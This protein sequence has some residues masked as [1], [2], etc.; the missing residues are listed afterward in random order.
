MIIERYAIMFIVLLVI[1]FLII[2]GFSN[3]FTYFRWSLIKDNTPIKF[4]TITQST[5]Y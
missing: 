1:A 5:I 2:I 3:A 4:G